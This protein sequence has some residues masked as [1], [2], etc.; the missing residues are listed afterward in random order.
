MAPHIRFRDRRSRTSEHSGQSRSA[1]R[2]AV[3]REPKREPMV[4]V[5]SCREHV[6]ESEVLSNDGSP[7]YAQSLS[8]RISESGRAAD[9]CRIGAEGL[10]G[11]KRRVWHSYRQFLRSAGRQIWE[12]LAS[13]AGG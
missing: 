12:G 10:S 2:R 9:R 7:C 4:I 1:R 6:T 5:V 3:R 13:A 11:C 8:Q